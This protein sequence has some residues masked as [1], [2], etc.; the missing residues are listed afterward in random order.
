MVS[1]NLTFDKFN[2]KVEKWSVYFIRFGLH[3]V[4]HDV[5]DKAKKQALLLSCQTPEIFN[6]LTNLCSPTNITTLTVEG[7]SDLMTKHFEPRKLRIAERFH[8]YKRDQR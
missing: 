6:L 4:A 5:S 8:F 2:P 3:C 1:S 7:I